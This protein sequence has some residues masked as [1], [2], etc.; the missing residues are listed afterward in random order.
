[1]SFTQWHCALITCDR[2]RTFSIGNFLRSWN[3][4]SLCVLIYLTD[5]NTM[6]LRTFH[7]SVCPYFHMFI[8]SRTIGSIYKGK[9]IHV[10]LKEESFSFQTGDNN[11]SAEIHSFFIFTEPILTTLG[12][13]GKGFPDPL[14]EVSRLFSRGDNNE[15]AKL[16]W[17][18]L[19][20]FFLQSHWPE[21]IVTKLCISIIGD[22]WPFKRRVTSL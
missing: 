19:K 15:I 17:R 20:I 14:K 16:Y 8:F 2:D 13:S 6:N 12:T 1:M 5:F 21:K 4:K 3:I 11:I 18:N 22:V 9:G 7:S 10:P